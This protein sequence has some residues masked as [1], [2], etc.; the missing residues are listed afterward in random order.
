MLD[1]YGCYLDGRHAALSAEA[2]GKVAPDD[3]RGSSGEVSDSHSGGTEA[4]GRSYVDRLV[5]QASSLWPTGASTRMADRRPSG[6]VTERRRFWAAM[7]T[8]RFGR[9]TWEPG[10][11]MR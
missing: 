8:M 2:A 1:V 3:G 6:S 4:V 11:A 5:E 7:R 10:S 9:S